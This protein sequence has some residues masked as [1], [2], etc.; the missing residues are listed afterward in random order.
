M[1]ATY[2]HGV[3]KQHENCLFHSKHKRLLNKLNNLINEGSFDTKATVLLENEGLAVKL[4]RAENAN[5]AVL[6]A[7]RRNKVAKQPNLVLL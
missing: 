7:N 3:G 2:K 6:G 1:Q 4:V 5:K